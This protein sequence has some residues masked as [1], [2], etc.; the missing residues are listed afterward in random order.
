MR[1][2]NQFQSW[3]AA[4][5]LLVAVLNSSEAQANLPLAD[6]ISGDIPTTS[7]SVALED[8]ITIPNSSGNNRPRLE[9][10]TGGGAAGLAYVIDQRGKIYTFDPTV[11]TPS[12]SLFFDVSSAVP[13]F[14]FNGQ[15]G[16]RGL[17]FHPDFNNQDTD[18]YRKFYTSHSRNF[19]TS[20]VGNPTTF[21]DPGFSNHYS[22]VGEWT[23]NA[24]GT[25]NTGSYRELMRVAQPV[26]DHNIG[27]IG[28][29]P[30]A[31]NS[32]HADY[33]NLYITMG[34][35]GSNA[36]PQTATDVNNHGQGLDEVFGSILRIDPLASGGSPYSVVTDNALN[37]NTSITNPRN[38]VW[39]YG[40]RNPHRFSFDTGGEQGMYISDIGQGNIE[41]VNLGAN[42][43]NYGWGVREGTFVDT[44]DPFINNINQLDTLPANHPTDA[45]TYPVAQYDHQNQAV[46]TS[47][48]AQPG[49]GAIAGGE[50]Y[51]GSAVPQL[52]GMF[53]FGDFANNTGPIFAVDVDELVQ[54]EDFTNLTNLSGGNLAPYE[55][56]R[57]TFGG[58]EKTMLQAIR[59]A[60]GNQSL[61]RTDIRLNLGPDGEFY[62][63]NKR[64]G[65][66]RRLV[67]VSGV[68]D[69]DTDRGGQ[70]NGGDF[71]TWQQGHGASDA[72]SDGNFNGDNAVDGADLTIWGDNYGSTSAVASSA[73][74]PEPT[75]IYLLLSMLLLSSAC[76]RASRLRL[77]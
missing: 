39:A 3:L 1:S 42:G 7:W 12:S 50:V 11:A 15:A 76:R 5:F 47:S 57:L 56:L 33:G 27:Q 44:K 16:V 36:F 49:N 70:V 48:P 21:A 54:R 55:E 74:V 46:G 4:G 68:L 28:F 53:I 61:G 64:D 30:N 17:A 66:I 37:V 59:D 29:S 62:V 20:A 63:L 77:Q 58:V 67:S 69:G 6:P 13:N 26:G 75:A 71:L 8:V 35:G 40:L 38:L 43:A 10:M 9:F 19:G 23:I 52:K 18:G 60:S 24:N 32:S 31:T 51:R 65:R 22:V 41:E 34:D 73:V 45:F 25:V 72:W 2:V 14:F